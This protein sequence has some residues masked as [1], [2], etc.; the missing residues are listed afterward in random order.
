MAILAWHCG[1]GEGEGE[2][3]NCAMMT[4]PPIQSLCLLLADTYTRISVPE[5]ECRRRARPDEQQAVA[6]AGDAS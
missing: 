5:A 2:G 3:G 4:G 6:P 1:R